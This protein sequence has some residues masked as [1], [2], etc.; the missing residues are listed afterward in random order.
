MAKVRR[1]SEL[2]KESLTTLS[3]LP[4]KIIWNKDMSKTAL[5]VANDRICRDDG[6]WQSAYKELATGLHPA[7]HKG[8]MYQMSDW[9]NAIGSIWSLG[10][11]L[12]LKDIFYEPEE[13]LTEKIGQIFLTSEKNFLVVIN[14]KKIS[15]ETKKSLKDF[16][17][18]LSL[19]LDADRTWKPHYWKALTIHDLDLHHG[20][21]WTQWNW[22]YDPGVNRHN[23]IAEYRGDFYET[24]KDAFYRHYISKIR[25]RPPLELDNKENDRLSEHEI[26][27][28]HYGWIRWKLHDAKVIARQ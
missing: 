17:W 11:E 26:N 8:S 24:S 21:G 22:D 3:G 15:S 23:C 4:S 14:A 2:S 5:Y 12:E 16:G 19:T 20:Y 1:K 28:A 13:E 6:D 25:L 27:D 7:K 10:K 9:F 18:K